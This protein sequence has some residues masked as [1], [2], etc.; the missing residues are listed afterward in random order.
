M[1][2]AIEDRE[3]DA[4]QRRAGVALQILAVGVADQ[5]V[6]RLGEQQRAHVPQILAGYTWQFLPNGE[7]SSSA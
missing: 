7:L 1:V 4:D 6:D 3:A 5:E 2:M